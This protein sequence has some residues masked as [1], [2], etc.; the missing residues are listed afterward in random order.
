MGLNSGPPHLIAPR[1]WQCPVHL[2]DLQEGM[3]GFG[4]APSLGPP[5]TAWFLN[6]GTGL[7]PPNDSRCQAAVRVKD[8]VWVGQ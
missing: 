7:F 5:L 2:G 1:G 6:L 3:V 8:G 4:G